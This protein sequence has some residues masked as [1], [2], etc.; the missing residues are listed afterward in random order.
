MNPS[1]IYRVLDRIRHPTGPT[2]RRDFL[3]LAAV[4]R[5]IEEEMDIRPDPAHDQM[6]EDMGGMPRRPW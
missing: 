3:T 6:V 5:I 2:R 4:V 1:G